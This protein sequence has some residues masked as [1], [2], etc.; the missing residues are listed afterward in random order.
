[1]NGL[2]LVGVFLMQMC[3]CPEPVLASSPFFHQ[4]TTCNEAFRTERCASPP[5]RACK[6]RGLLSRATPAE[7]PLRLSILPMLVPSLSWQNDHFTCK[8]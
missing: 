3:V 1:M 8:T 7:T 5:R 2:C 6:R 4:K